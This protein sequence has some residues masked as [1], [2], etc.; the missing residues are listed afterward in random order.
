[1]S[2][3]NKIWIGNIDAKL[4]EY[5]LLKICEAFGKIIAFNFLYSMNTKTNN[6]RGMSSGRG[7]VAIGSHRVPRGYAFVT[8]E[9]SKAA[10]DAIQQLNKK[11][12]NGRELQVRYATSTSTSSSA[13]ETQL[14][15]PSVLSAGSNVSPAAA[16]SKLDKIRQLEAKLKNLEGGCDGKS[17]LRYKPY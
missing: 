12:L 3:D 9:C 7:G 6:H 10:K 14:N 17:N 15:L 1:M 8:Y 4:S 11:T 16:A 5:Q 2:G 13:I